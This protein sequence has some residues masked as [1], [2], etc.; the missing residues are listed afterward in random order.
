[1][2][3]RVDWETGA[4]GVSELADEFPGLLIGVNI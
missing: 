4:S 2:T 3:V 1:M